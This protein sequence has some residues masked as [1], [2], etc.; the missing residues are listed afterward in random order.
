VITDSTEDWPAQPLHP[1]C[2]V[3]NTIASGISPGHAT[4]ALLLTLR[5]HPY[6]EFVRDLCFA[7]RRL[8]GEYLKELEGK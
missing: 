6:E 8:H 5:N 7:H 1:G 2:V 4:M 3:C